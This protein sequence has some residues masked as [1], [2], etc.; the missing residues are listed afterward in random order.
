MS[1]EETRRG[2]VRRFLQIFA[3]RVFEGAVLFGSAGTFR[4]WGA[5]FY[6]GVV[7]ALLVAVG[8]YLIP[9]NPEI[10]VERSKVHEGTAGFDKVVMT[11]YAL[12]Y[13]AVLVVAG[14]DA[15]RFG[16]AP[17]GYPWMA[18][19]AVLIVLGMIPMTAA[20]AVNRNLEPTVRIQSDRGHQVAT[21]GP[22]RI[23]RHPMYAGML[24]MMPG[25]PLALGST[26]A[27]VPTVVEV[28]LLF[29]RTALEDR[30]LRR[31]LAGYEEFTKQTRYRLIPGIW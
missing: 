3:Q 17:L 23:V 10:I 26:W 30:M 27:F 11:F 20:M 5:W 28:A 12:S 15:G 2:M 4:Y 9:R 6:F 1:A 13:V 25:L 16:W 7:T 31:E 22:Y 21:E 19:G 8:V 18:L 29:L 24:V 14:L